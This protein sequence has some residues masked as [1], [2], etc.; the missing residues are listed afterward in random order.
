MYKIN[1]TADT[2]EIINVGII[3]GNS[4]II[5]SIYVDSKRV[6]T[7]LLMKWTVIG[8]RI[9]SVFRYKIHIQIPNKN[10]LIIPPNSWPI[11][12]KN[13]ETKIAGIIPILSFN[14]LSSMPLKTS[15][16]TRGARIIVPRA[17]IKNAT[18]VRLV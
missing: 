13:E 5:I 11:P 14:R 9:L 16:S 12:N 6:T 8:I 3:Q 1:K 18:G 15:S 10:A 7:K 2:T 17:S 4:N